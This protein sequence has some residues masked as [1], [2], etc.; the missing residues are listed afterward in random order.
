M[1]NLIRPREQ[2]L[3]RNDTFPRP[4]RVFAS[5]RQRCA[6]VVPPRCWLTVPEGVFTLR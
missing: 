5:S 6:V 1:R 4:N 2:I 3:F